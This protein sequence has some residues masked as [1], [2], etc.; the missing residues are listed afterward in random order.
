V[1]PLLTKSSA[2]LGTIGLLMVFGLPL[3]WLVLTSLKTGQQLA[4]SPAGVFFEPTVDAYKQALTPT[5]FRSMI[6][7]VAI[8]LPTSISLLALGIP[9][10]FGLSRAPRPLANAVLAIL[11]ILQMVP[12]AVSLVPLYRVL[13]LSHLINTIPG[14][15]CADVALYLPF[16]IILLRPFC[17]GLPKD[18]LDA[19]AIDGA[20]TPRILF[21]IVL[22]LMRNGAATVGALTFILAWGEFI[23]ALTFLNDSSLQ[24]LSAL[25]ARQVTAYGVDWPSLMAISAVASLPLLVI[26]LLVQRQLRAGLTLGTGK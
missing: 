26:Y 12:P 16:A 25:L 21:H 9:A 1:I 20:G 7:S 22:P 14:I 24:P 5:L 11:L 15:V 13:G 17:L 19:A 3:V 6:L 23:Y 8:A 2:R 18:L 10:A 4:N